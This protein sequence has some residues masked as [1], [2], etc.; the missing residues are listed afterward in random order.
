MRYVR[1]NGAG[2]CSLEDVGWDGILRLLG[3][4]AAGPCPTKQHGRN[5]ILSVAVNSRRLDRPS[6]LFKVSV[7]RQLKSFAP[8]KETAPRLTN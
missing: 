3:K 6:Y 5:P 7:S 1:C 8:G 2:A 4:A